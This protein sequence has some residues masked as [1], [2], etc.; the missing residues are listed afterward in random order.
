M[1]LLVSINHLKVVNMNITV[2]NILRETIVKIDGAYAPATIRAYRANFER[3]IEFCDSKDVLALPANKLDVADFIRH[4]SDS[5]LKS[6]SIRIAV[7]SISAMHRLNEAPDPTNHPDVK[8]EL[9]RMHR[10]L[11]RESKQ[12]AGINAELL[13]RMVKSTDRTLRGIRD[14]ALL[15]TAYDS[16]CR[17]SEL[18]SL[19]VNDLIINPKN[20]S[21]KIKLRRSKTDQDGLGRWLHLGIDSQKAIL[22]WIKSSGIKDGMLFRGITRGEKITEGL[23]AAQINRIYKRIAMRSKVDK[24]VVKHIS[25][26]S[27]RVG[28]AQDLLK[29]GASLPMMMQRGRWSKADTVMRYLEKTKGISAPNNKRQTEWAAS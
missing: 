18:V 4:L 6:A 11:G 28:A 29:S 7:A 12:A 8:I 21:V 9:R 3:F 25:G 20:R 17:R 19:T 23:S 5:D 10:N 1:T 26:H 22:Q 15:L 24:S 16:M 14:R 13:G 27:M 2:K